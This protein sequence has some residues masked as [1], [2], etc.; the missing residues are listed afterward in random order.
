MY[1]HTKLASPRF[2]PSYFLPVISRSV[3]A[4]SS[5]ATLLNLTWNL[6]LKTCTH[7]TL[8]WPSSWPTALASA[9]SNMYNPMCSSTSLTVRPCSLPSC[10][11]WQHI[12]IY[13]YTHTF[14]YIKSTFLFSRNEIHIAAL[15]PLLQQVYFTIIILQ[16]HFSVVFWSCR[17]FW[18]IHKANQVCRLVHLYA[19][20]WVG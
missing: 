16:K 8:M 11:S 6:W 10:F 18:F 14:I 9:E 12:Y 7:G 19:P 17:F 3:L 20:K 2:S 13:K 5:G 1:L 15:K 4:G